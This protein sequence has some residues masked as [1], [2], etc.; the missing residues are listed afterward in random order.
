M[1]APKI[2]KKRL[3]S[4][5]WILPLVAFMIGG[6]LLYSPSGS[7]WLLTRVVAGQNWSIGAIKG[8]LGGRLKLSDL[9]VGGPDGHLSCGKIALTTRLRQLLPLRP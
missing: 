1:Q 3:V 8:T 5:I 4:P 6:W 2:K 9:Q 7:A